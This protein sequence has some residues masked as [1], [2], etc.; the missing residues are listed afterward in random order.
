MQNTR[1]SKFSV[2]AGTLG[3]LGA[4]LVVLADLVGILVVERHNPISETISRLAAGKYGW[5]QDAGFVA[6][7]IGLGAIGIG[8]FLWNRGGFRW[9]FAAVLLSLLAPDMLL[10]AYYNQDVA[11]QQQPGTSIHL[12]GAYFLYAVFCLAVLLFGFEF[13]RTRPPAA[14]FSFA[15]FLFWLVGGPAFQFVISTSWDGVLERLLGLAMVAWVLMV[16]WLLR[17][18]GKTSSAS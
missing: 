1:E 7:A 10:L 11:R 12:C 8:L 16:S 2:Y 14:Y 6:F 15:V 5:I 13:R 18:H 17:Q 3:L 4:I 9:R